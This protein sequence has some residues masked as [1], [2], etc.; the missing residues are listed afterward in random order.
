ME[1]RNIL[2]YKYLLWAQPPGKP[3]RGGNKLQEVRS[4]LDICSPYW[5][6]KYW[7]RF[8][9]EAQ[10]T[11]VPAGASTLPLY[12][13]AIS[14]SLYLILYAA[15]FVGGIHLTTAEMSTCSDSHPSLYLQPMESNTHFNIRF[16]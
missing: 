4:S 1:K 12:D 10:G 9:R 15:R 3:C 7:E 11:L 5:T 16:I 8:P 2:V 6:Q 13:I 14:W